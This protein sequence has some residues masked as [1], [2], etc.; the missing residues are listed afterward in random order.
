MINSKSFTIYLIALIAVH[1]SL[2]SLLAAPT[3]AEFLMLNPSVR[4]SASGGTTFMAQDE[5]SAIFLNPALSLLPHKSD[6]KTTRISAAYSAWTQNTSF[7]SFAADF[8]FI[9]K[10][11]IGIGLL[12][13][14]ASDIERRDAAGTLLSGNLSATNLAFAISYAKQIAN[15]FSLGSSVKIISLD[16]APSYD[17]TTAQSVAA[18]IGGVYS[19]S[20]T[21]ALC[22]SALNIG[23]DINGQK[24]PLDFRLAIS[25]LFNSS[26][27]ISAEAEYPI[28]IGIKPKIGAEYSFNYEKNKTFTLR[29]GAEWL[30]GDTSIS[31]G[32]GFRM[33]VGQNPN[34]TDEEALIKEN[35]LPLKPF[36]ILFDYS[37]TTFTSQDITPA[38]RISLGIE[39]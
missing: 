28:H 15:N 23:P 38:H 9:S 4:S 6:D 17:G 37:F 35:A 16:Y 2:S 30:K 10:S 12:Y 36:N 26:L 3:T 13:F 11:K 14:G 20:D 18:D 21:T 32:A 33:P 7:G 19:F 34:S 22:L 39:F 25:H 29:A 5:P 24:T 8:P 31:A 27:K 1:I